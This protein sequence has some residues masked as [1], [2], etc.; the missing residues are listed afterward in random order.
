MKKKL[1]VILMLTVLCVTL[2]CGINTVFAE[3]ADGAEI[4]VVSDDI[5]TKGVYVEVG[6]I[7]RNHH[8]YREEQFHS[9]VYRALRN[10]R[11]VFVRRVHD[12]L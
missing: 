3:E 10:R 6:L 12:V 9:W 8:R 7:K 11:I 5:E 2:A 1:C 4:L